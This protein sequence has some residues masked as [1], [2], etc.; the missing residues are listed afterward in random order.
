MSAQWAIAIDGKNT[1][2]KKEKCL[3]KFNWKSVTW[4]KEKSK[5]AQ[6]ELLSKFI[7][8]LFVIFINISVIEFY[9]QVLPLL[10]L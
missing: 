2:K 3:G 6:G 7:V 5:I 1:T 9:S 4:K 8:F 10:S